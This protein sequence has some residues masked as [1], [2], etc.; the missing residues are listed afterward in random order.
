MMD[1]N[2]LLM[3]LIGIGTVA[4]LVGGF[5]LGVQPSLQ[6]AAASDA[7]RQAAVQT[8]R[9]NQVA[10]GALVAQNKKIGELTGQLEKLRLSVP[11]TENMPAF[12]DAVDAAAAAEGLIVQDVTPSDAV[13]YA[14]QGAAAPAAQPAPQASATASPTPTAS[15]TPAPTLTTPPAAG[16]QTPAAHTDPS[17][18][19]ANFLAVPIK[20][21][22]AGPLDR[23]IAFVHRLQTGERLF[24]VSGLTG[25]LDGGGS[26]GAAGGA[27]AAPSETYAVTGYIYVLAKAASPTGQK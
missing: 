23:T 25:G 13:A 7:A 20:I 18:T 14:P 24:L 26:N 5:L 19:A 4:V 15:S 8:N 11:A 9:V 21:G 1:K 16:A 3:V 6:A 17:I 27:T 22:V 12:L 10:L 2:K